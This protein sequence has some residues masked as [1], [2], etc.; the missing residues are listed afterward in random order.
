MAVA[1]LAAAAAG[2]IVNVTVFK[3]RRDSE[4]LTDNVPRIAGIIAFVSSGTL[5]L[6]FSIS[7]ILAVI[8]RGPKAFLLGGVHTNRD[9]KGWELENFDH[10]DQ[11]FF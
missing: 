11:K 9:A 2:T 4:V 5:F 10:V 1:T 3:L 6:L 8:A 7:M